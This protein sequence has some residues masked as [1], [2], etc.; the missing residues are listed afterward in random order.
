MQG[1]EFMCCQAELQVSALEAWQGNPPRYVEPVA[2]FLLLCPGKAA[3]F[4]LPLPPVAAFRL[5]FSFNHIQVLSQRMCCMDGLVT[6][7]HIQH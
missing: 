4:K 5:G 7:I 2:E 6:K 1:W 3:G